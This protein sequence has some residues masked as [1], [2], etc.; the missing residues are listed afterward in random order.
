MN[1]TTDQ[2]DV[3]CGGAIDSTIKCIEE[4]C[5][6][7]ESKGFSRSQLGLSIDYDQQVSIYAE[8]EMTDDEADELKKEAASK[9]MKEIDSALESLNE[10]R[11]SLLETING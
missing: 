10:R 7:L 1:Y 4:A 3:D 5:S 9:E 11:D 2:V 6:Q 8:R